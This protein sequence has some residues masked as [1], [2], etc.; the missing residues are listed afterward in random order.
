M[1]GGLGMWVGTLV[2]SLV[3]RSP[4]LESLSSR[5]RMVLRQVP[6]GGAGPNE[7]ASA[8]VM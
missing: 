3:G 7:D 2:E 6:A 8:T 4:R 1:G 5:C